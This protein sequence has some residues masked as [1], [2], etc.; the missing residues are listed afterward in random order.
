MIV[1]CVDLP[2]GT[3]F[4]IIWDNDKKPHIPLF[5]DIDEFKKIFEKYSEEVYPQ[6]Y[7]FSDLVNVAKDDLVINPASESLVLN[8][9]TFKGQ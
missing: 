3:S 8:P 5:T 6:A 1:G 2:N 7:N 9:E 4:A